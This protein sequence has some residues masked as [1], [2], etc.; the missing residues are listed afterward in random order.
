[1]RRLNR[2]VRVCG[3]VKNTGEPGGGPFWVEG[4]SGETS[5]QIVETAQIDPDDKEQQ[6]MLAL[7]EH[8]ELAQHDVMQ[9]IAKTRKRMY[10][11][12]KERMRELR[13]RM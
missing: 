4:K 2:P 7:G 10:Q 11:E 1:M 5:L 8:L 13:R 12:E 9:I 3:M 6:A